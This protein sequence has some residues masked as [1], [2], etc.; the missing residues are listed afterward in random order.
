MLTS[1]TIVT[2][3]VKETGLAQGLFEKNHGKI[4]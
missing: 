4:T 1:E 3:I 2:F